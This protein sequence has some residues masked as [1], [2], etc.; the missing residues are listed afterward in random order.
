MGQDVDDKNQN[1]DNLL[2]SVDENKDCFAILEIG[3][4]LLGLGV[5]EI[6]GCV[7]DKDQNVDNLL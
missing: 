7:D 2:K 1:V 4:V 3:V 6:K 5:D